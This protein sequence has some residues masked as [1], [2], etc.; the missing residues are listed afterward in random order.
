MMTTHTR[1]LQLCLAVLTLASFTV[2]ARPKGGSHPNPILS[3]AADKTNYAV[4]EKAQLSW[5][6]T[7]TR[8]CVASG[9]WDG[10][11]GTDGVFWTP[12]LDSA[13]T[14]H[15]KC[16][17][18]GGGVSATVQLAVTA[19]DTRPADPPPEPDPLPAPTAS[20]SAADGTVSEG[21]STTLSWSSTNATGC[22]GSGWGGVLD[23]DG[24]LAVGPISGTT[25][26]SVTC[27]GDAGSA[28]DSVEVAVTAPE[29]LP[30]EPD[31]VPKPTVALSAADTEVAGGASTLLTWSS[32]DATGCQGDGWGG[33]LSSGG[34]LSVGPIDRSTTYSLT[35][36]GD[37]GSA[38]TSVQVTVIPA[39][40]VSLS[41]ADSQVNAG[42]TTTLTWS[43][44]N[45]TGCQADGGWSGGRDPSGS[46]QVGPINGSTT[47]SLSCSG[48][49]G[50]AV[51]MVSV[52]ASGEV[53]ISWVKPNENVDG[54]PLT[55]LARYRIYYGT[56]SRSYSGSVEV[57]NPGATSHSFTAG[58][59]EY[60]VSMTAVDM[61]GNESAFSNEILRSVP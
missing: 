46:Q 1:F 21:G 61:D 33:A 34:S 35:C 58:S 57:T 53:S 59:G 20:L 42:G 23:A 15:L 18:K 14:Y 41:A 2:E 13:G 56:E 50:N 17:A 3:F 29:P 25:T 55:D 19:D 39:P 31:P 7:N 28:T 36:S 11:F 44:T 9:D 40:T 47:F 24:S 10:K 49:G 22:E 37:G 6:S 48:T 16:S 52:S 30:P 32:T 8:F 5:A 26:F 27:T 54:T 38:S 45:A 60:F 4:G 12:P 51:Q 43:S